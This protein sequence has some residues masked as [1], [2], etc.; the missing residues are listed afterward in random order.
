[1]LLSSKTAAS[2]SQHPHPV[3]PPPPLQSLSLFTRVA[4]QETTTKKSGTLTSRPP[5]LVASRHRSGPTPLS[6][7]RETDFSYHGQPTKAQARPARLAFLGGDVSV[8]FLSQRQI[9]SFTQSSDWVTH[10]LT[11]RTTLL[12]ELRNQFVSNV[13]CN[14]F[15]GF[16]GNLAKINGNGLLFSLSLSLSLPRLSR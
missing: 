1:M 15:V 2:G 6:D 13:H 5:W 16:E 10:G 8:L 3:T 7:R 9:E 11:G 12:F 14:L 4:T